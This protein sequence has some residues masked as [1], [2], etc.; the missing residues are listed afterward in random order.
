MRT[1][2]KTLFLLPACAV[3]ITSRMSPAFATLFCRNLENN[4]AFLSTHCRV[5]P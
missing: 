5:M 1:F 3:L 4:V 2:V